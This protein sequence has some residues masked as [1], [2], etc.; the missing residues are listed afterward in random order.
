MIWLDNSRIIAAFAAVFLHTAAAL[1]KGSYIGTEYW[2]TGNFYDSFVRWCVP[3]F[4]MISGALL[5][6]PGKKE[7]LKTFYRKRA[8]KIAVPVLFWS[9]F[10]SLWTM[11]KGMIKQDIPSLFDII[12][13][14]GSGTPYYHMWFLYMIIPLYLVTPFFRKIIVTSTRAELT[15]LVVFIFLMAA[16]NAAFSKIF[17]CGSELFTNWF[18]SYIQY[19][20]LGHLIRTSNRR[21]PKTILWGVFLLSVCLTAFGV[22][23]VAVDINLNTGLYFRGYLSITVIP[24]SISIMYLLKSWTIPVINEKF[25]KKLALL[26]FG[27]YLIHPIVLEIIKYSNIGLLNFHPVASIPVTALIVFA[28]SLIASWGIDQVPYLNHVI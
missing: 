17:P 6:D 8:S 27:I 24:M 10:F 28:L 12:K 13:E 14:V 11:L 22:Y 21:F 16:L 20:F 15:L 2:W 19:F 18:L 9:A 1:V 4:V 25:T 26:T 7:D 3:V 5:L 23:I